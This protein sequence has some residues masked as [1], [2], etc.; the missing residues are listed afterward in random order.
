MI[1]GQCCSQCGYG[2]FKSL[3]IQTEKI[4]IAFHYQNL[5]FF[6]V[7]KFFCQ[8]QPEKFAAFVKDR[9]FRRVQI[10]G[11]LGF[12]NQPAPESHDLR[13]QISD[14]KKQA[15]A[16]DIVAIAFGRTVDEP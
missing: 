11:A 12:G 10:F 4:E 3:R 14:R 8:T 2:R 6:T 15:G 9:I 7:N 5:R 13:G 16:K 1:V